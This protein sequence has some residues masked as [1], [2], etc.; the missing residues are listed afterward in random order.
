LNLEDELLITSQ[1]S[2]AALNRFI[3][4]PNHLVKMPGPGQDIFAMLWSLITEPVFKGLIIGS[5]LEFS[6]PTRPFDL[7]DESIGSFLNR[8]LRSPDPGNNIVSAILHGVYAGD[9]Y[10]LSMKSLGP[11]A[12]YQENMHGSIS[13]ATLANTNSGER[14]MPT[15]DALL[16]QD[17]VPKLKGLVDKM[18]GASV[19]TFRGGLGTLSDTLTKSLEA[20]HNVQFKMEQKISDVEYTSSSDSI[21][22]RIHLCSSTQLTVLDQNQQQPPTRRL[23]TLHIYPPRPPPCLCNSTPPNP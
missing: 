15:K 16:Q 23:Y 12:W 14:T 4:Y 1:Y 22:V 11:M 7:E 8:R 18:K 3:Y 6:Q 13:Q 9:I 20:N 5:I 21:K 10:Q 19:Y 2:I 17:M